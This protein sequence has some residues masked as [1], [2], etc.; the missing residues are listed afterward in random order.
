MKN[1]TYGLTWKLLFGISFLILLTL[2]ACYPLNGSEQGVNPRATWTPMVQPT[3]QPFQFNSETFSYFGKTPALVIFGS[4]NPENETP[5][6][7]LNISTDDVYDV[8]MITP[9]PSSTW[10]RPILTE[11]MELY[12]QVGGTLYILSPGGQNRSIELPY[13]EENPAYCNWSWKGQLVCLNAAMTTGF[14][15]DQGLNVVALQLPAEAEN[16]SEMYYEPYRVGENTMRSVQRMTRPVNGWETVFYK[17]LDLETGTVQSLQIQIEAD[18]NRD[19]SFKPG[20]S[21]PYVHAI[22]EGG[23]VDVIGI[24]ETGDKVYISSFITAIQ[25]R[26][27]KR[28]LAEYYD[29]L[30]L[31]LLNYD[32]QISHASEKN[33]YK[34]YVIAGWVFDADT[35]VNTQPSVI[36]LET[37]EIVF[38]AAGSLNNNEFV[39]FILPYGDDW[40]AGDSSGVHYYRGNGNWMVSYP[41]SDEIIE[42]LDQDSYYT[43][44]QPI[45]PE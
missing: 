28:W 44:S 29:G 42:S 27:T 23:N 45:E 4:R 32:I 10:S 35:E 25:Y 9:A 3:D 34:H 17:D 1:K 6:R 2:Q 19:F 11:D 37:G 41:F 16:G 22:Q 30:S 39:N 8:S 36:D 12:F 14:L 7:V 13:D 18:F 5:L 20:P 33:F 24:S 15:V 31:V 38:E 21:A 26:N 40:I 43:I